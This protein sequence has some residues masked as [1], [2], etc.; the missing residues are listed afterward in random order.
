MV[1]EIVSNEWPSASLWL[2]S[3]RRFGCAGRG[4]RCNLEKEE[5]WCWAEEL[6]SQADS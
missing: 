4:G 1:S 2:A 5:E 6:T 3:M